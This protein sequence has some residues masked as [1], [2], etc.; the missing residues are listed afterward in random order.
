MGAGAASISKDLL[1]KVL[2]PS[3]DHLGQELKGLTEKGTENLKRIFSKAR[4]RLGSKPVDKG[5][6]PL[7]VIKG[8][9][10]DGSFCDDELGAEYFG[11]VLASSKSEVPQDDRGASLIALITRLSSYQIRAH[12]IFYHV[13]KTMFDETGLLPVW[14]TPA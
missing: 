4:H 7:K 11:G 10:F 6:V 8:V 3:A 1:L 2:G 5:S 9:W 13:L 14:L 12:Y